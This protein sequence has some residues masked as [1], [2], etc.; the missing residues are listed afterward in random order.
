MSGTSKRIFRLVH[1]LVVD[2]FTMAEW[3]NALYRFCNGESNPGLPMQDRFAREHLIFLMRQRVGGEKKKAEAENEKNVP[4]VAKSPASAEKMLADYI[5]IQL[6]SWQIFYNR[7][8]IKFD[9]SK[10]IVPKHQFGYK[11]LIVV[12]PRMRP[13][14][15]LNICESLFECRDYSYNLLDMLS[16]SEDRSAILGPYAIWVK[17][18]IEPDSDFLGKSANEILKKK[19]NSMTLTERLIF[20]AKFFVEKGKH[21]D[22]EHFTLCPGSR[23]SGQLVAAVTWENVT[24][25]LGIGWCTIDNDSVYCGIR[26]AIIE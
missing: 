4:A 20:A 13:Q 3:D 24:N 18:D 15:A 1:E 19:I 9:V 17:D 16:I 11:R 22:M 10:V 21:L 8:G 25:M 2:G 14:Q 12:A 23:R 5:K 6:Q 26:K 7:T